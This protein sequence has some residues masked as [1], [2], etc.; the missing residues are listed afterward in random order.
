MF[1]LLQ[2]ILFTVPVFMMFVHNIHLQITTQ[3]KGVQIKY[4]TNNV[5]DSMTEF[6][7]ILVSLKHYT[8]YLREKTFPMYRI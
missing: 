2:C 8:F 1:G 7:K 3:I 6:F 4:I 5:M